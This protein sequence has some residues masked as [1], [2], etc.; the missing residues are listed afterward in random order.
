MNI[1]SSTTN[2]RYNITDPATGKVRKLTLPLH[3]TVKEKKQQI[4][5]HKTYI[6]G[7]RLELHKLEAKE[8][9]IQ[10][11]ICRRTKLKSQANFILKAQ[12]IR[13]QG[14]TLLADLFPQYKETEAYAKV[15]A[16]VQYQREKQF[17][18]FTNYLTDK[19]KVEY[20]EQISTEHTKSFMNQL[21]GK[22]STFNKYYANIKNITEALG[23]K[24]LFEE[25]SRKNAEADAKPKEPFTEEQVHKIID[26]FTGE[27]HRLVLLGSNSGLRLTDCVHLKKENVIEDYHGNPI[28]KLVPAKTSHT[29]RAL[30][31]QITKPIEFLLTAQVDENG[32]FFP[33]LV[34][35]YK[36]GTP[37]AGA[38]LNHV[39]QK[40][41]KSLGITGKGFHS[42]RSYFIDKLRR[43]GFSN[44]EIGSIVGHSTVK[45]TRDYGDFHNV[46]NLQKIV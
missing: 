28:I 4:K 12:E 11:E 30:Y 1:T 29:G 15:S 44:E 46:I 18:I 14:Q 7:L 39:F 22:A 10:A 6:A 16:K 17:A 34:K 35:M 13:N 32:Y 19:H 3:G 37:H 41:L 38:S 20:K 40:K 9:L 31:I 43:N 5:E 8:L 21:Q 25:I 26:N 27:W 36:K 23:L 24:G 42:F 45:Q 2:Y 33:K